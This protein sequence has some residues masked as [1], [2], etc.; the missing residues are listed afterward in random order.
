MGNKRMV[1]AAITPTDATRLNQTVLLS[2]VVYL[3]TREGPEAIRLN[4]IHIH[5]YYLLSLQTYRLRHYNIV[6]NILGYFKTWDCL[7]RLLSQLLCFFSYLAIHVAIY[8][9]VFLACKSYPARSILSNPHPARKKTSWAVQ[10]GSKA[11]CTQPVTRLG[12]RTRNVGCVSV[13]S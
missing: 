10:L 4:H 3:I 1:E 7:Q 11:A 2:R 6:Q 5:N 9:Y 8:G 13:T 12:R